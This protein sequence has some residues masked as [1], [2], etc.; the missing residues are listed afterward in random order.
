MIKCLRWVTR[1][2][3]LDGSWL[4]LIMSWSSMIICW[5]SLFFW[6]QLFHVSGKTTFVVL[7][8]S[9]WGYLQ[10]AARSVFVFYIDIVN[11]ARHR[12]LRASCLSW[13]NLCKE[14]CSS[15]WCS[16]L[17]YCWYCEEN[18]IVCKIESWRFFARW[19]WIDCVENLCFSW[20]LKN[21]ASVLLLQ[22]YCLLEFLIIPDAVDP[23]CLTDFGCRL[24]VELKLKRTLRHAYQ[25]CQCQCLFQVK[26][27]FLEGL[28]C[29]SAAIL[30]TS[31]RL[32]GGEMTI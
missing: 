4:C 31:I 17:F 15:L 18:C 12:Y 5:S 24:W 21:G 3:V 22:D 32:N 10:P 14:V 1:F 25:I 8:A 27:M 6:L 9:Q 30:F 28:P 16:A 7:W 20:C 13:V 23:F 11:Y 26:I 2:W 19:F 29:W